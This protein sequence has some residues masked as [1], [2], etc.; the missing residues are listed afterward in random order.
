[1]LDPTASFPVATATNPNKK[2]AGRETGVVYTPAAIARRIVDQVLGERVKQDSLQPGQPLSILDP[3]CG[4]GVFL[5]ECH[6]W[7]IDWHVD[8]HQSHGSGRSLRKFGGK[9]QLSDDE[10]HRVGQ[11]HLYGTDI[12]STS[13]DQTRRTL[14]MTGVEN[15]RVGNA[16]ISPVDP[17][18]PGMSE[19]MQAFD[20]QLEFPTVARVGGFDLVIGNPPYVNIRRIH[21]LYG[22]QI[23]KQLTQRFQTAVGNFDLYVLFCEKAL[24]WLRAGGQFAMIV[25]NKIGTLDYAR[26]CRRLLLEQTTID[27][28][29]DLSNLPVFPG[30]GVYPFVLH[31]TNRRPDEAH[32]VKVDRYENLEELESGGLPTTTQVRQR[33]LSQQGFQLHG[34]LEV[35]QRVATL[36]LSEVGQLHSGTTGFVA[37]QVAS[38]LREAGSRS[39]DDF[40][41]IVSGNIDRY[42]LRTGNVRFMKR[43]FESPVLASGSSVISTGKRRLFQHPKI[44]IAGMTRRLEATWVEDPLALG[45][46]VYAVSDLKFDPLYVLGLLNSKLLTYLFHLRFAAKKLSGGFMAINK[47]QLSQLPIRLIQPG[48]RAEARMAKQLRAAVSRMTDTFDH[49]VDGEIDQIVY[50]LY[51]LTP[52]EVQ[53]V[54]QS[55]DKLA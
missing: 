16:L 5:A 54:E 18:P 11:R 25:P 35:E 22:P 32:Q 44:A 27:R 47:G 30:T 13:V 31:W 23:K 20:W 10:C 55:V 12:D 53:L 45:V 52:R 1:M 21:Q 39:A 6:R 46:Q 33:S 14:A 49:S 15:I 17:L 40:P 48:R 24:E 36:P 43:F 37:Q 42:Q 41:F 28:I 29:T 2:N 26:S 19:T 50:K 9:W 7:L 38:E 4:Q 51:A 34:C 8:W 3:A